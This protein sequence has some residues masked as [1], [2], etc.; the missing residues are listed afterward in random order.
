M[1]ELFEIVGFIAL[2][3]VCVPFIL[4]MTACMVDELLLSNSLGEHLTKKF[5]KR[6]GGDE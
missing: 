6:F 1:T 5:K 2:A 4:A 3:S